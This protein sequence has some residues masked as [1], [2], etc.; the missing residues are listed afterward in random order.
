MPHGGA[1]EG[2]YGVSEYNQ[3]YDDLSKG[4]AEFA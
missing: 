4:L 3:N 1:H 2:R